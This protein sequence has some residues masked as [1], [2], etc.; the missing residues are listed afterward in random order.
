MS[1]YYVLDGT[2]NPVVET[3]IHKWARWFDGAK[4][5]RIVEKT[6]IKDIMVST[7]FLA[8]D[9]NYGGKGP[10]ILWE[11]LVFGGPMEGEQDRCA[12]VREQAEAMHR[13]MVDRVSASVV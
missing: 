10:P 4:Q 6:L 11:T 3:D 13:K 7:V 5:E 9:H 2:G 1:K 12:G 8:L